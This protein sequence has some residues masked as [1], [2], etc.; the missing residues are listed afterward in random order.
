MSTEST[1]VYESERVIAEFKKRVFIQKPEQ[2]ILSLLRPSLAEARVLDIGVGGG[3]TSR[4]FTDVREYVGIDLSTGMVE[5]CQQRYRGALNMRFLVCDVRDMHVF[6]EE[7]FDIAFF[8]FNG[9][10]CL[11]QEDRHRALREIQR[12]LKSK[13]YFIFSSHN[14]HFAPQLFRKVR[15]TWNPLYFIRHML[16][17]MKRRKLN[18]EWRSLAEK[19]YAIIHDGGPNWKLKGLRFPSYYVDPNHQITQL[20]N[21][22]FGNVRTF[23]LSTGLEITTETGLKQN[24]DPWLYYFC[25]R[26]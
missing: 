7:S 4:F 5:A 6:P 11:S 2:T 16:F 1:N 10:D 15:P 23:S 17:N 18:P 9:I 22:G 12:L 14:I 13:G 19:N 21:T 26:R 8:S 24:R 25:Q 20:H 3:R